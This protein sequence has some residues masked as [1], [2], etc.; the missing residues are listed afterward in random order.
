[1]IT[2]ACPQ[3]LSPTSA[4]VVLRLSVCARRSLL[5]CAPP[6]V[7]NPSGAAPRPFLSFTVSSS[8]NA[9]PAYPP[10]EGELTIA[11][12]VDSHALIA[13]E[14]VRAVLLAEV[15]GGIIYHLEKEAYH[16]GVAPVVHTNLH[17][18]EVVRRLH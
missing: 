5:S 7:T 8:F 10:C 4:S 13:V 18:E 1:M 16:K 11:T 3:S 17:V 9:L 14:S 15:A 2:V 6:S 12:D